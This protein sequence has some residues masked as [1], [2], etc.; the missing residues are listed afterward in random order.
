MTKQKNVLFLV[1]DQMRGDCLFGALSEHVKLPN[2]RALMQDAVSFRNHYSVLSPCGPSRASLLT[3]QYGM[4]HRAVRNGTPMPHDKPN[5][6]KEVR[7]A[8]YLPLLYGST[9]VSHDPRVVSAGDPAFHS[10]EEVIPGFQEVIRQRQEDDHCPWQADLKAKGYDLPPYPDLYQ[11]NGSDIDD[12]AIYSAEDSDTA[13]LA[14]AFLKDIAIRPQ[15]WFAH[16]TFIRPHPPFVAPEP[17]NRMYD[18][19]TMPKPVVWGSESDERARHPYISPCLDRNPISSVV[20]GFPDLKPTEE[21]IDK[22]RAIYMGLA[23]ELDHH[24]GRIIAWLKESGQYDDTLVV[25]TSDHGELLGDFHAW[26]K[27]TFYDAAFQTPL[28]IRDPDHTGGYGT[29]VDLP[30]E[31]VD[32]SPTILDLLGLDIPHSMDGRSLQPLLAGQAPADWRDYSYSELDFGNPIEPDFWQKQLGL[33]IDETNLAVLRTDSHTLVQFAGQMPPILF[34]R[35]AEG[36]KRDISGDPGASQIL[37]DL[38]QRMLCHRMR[39]PEGQF[40]R[41]KVTGGGLQIGHD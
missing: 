7:K 10:Y 22:I 11:P 31:S 30:T 19:A 23:T 1:I 33:H 13:F 17:Y 36:E 5:I 28:I 41:M 32:I 3:G 25:I 35:K 14:D 6:A 16:L 40:S 24:I 29:V 37:L 2:L 12:P 34:D 39:N 18:P 20:E 4:N 21:N 9:D 15:G 8:G 38:T 26:G 27:T